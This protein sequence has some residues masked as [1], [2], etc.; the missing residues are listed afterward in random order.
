[1]TYGGHAERGF[2]MANLVAKITL[3]LIF[4]LPTLGLAA[5]LPRP[6]QAPVKD[7]PDALVL[8]R[9][10]DQARVYCPR[11]DL[12]WINLRSLVFHIE[13]CGDPIFKARTVSGAYVCK[14]E[15]EKWPG[16]SADSRYQKCN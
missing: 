10:E 8:F 7:D 4:T 12:A 16:A 5:D 15:A 9:T 6:D 1:L 11:D 14:S 3:A 2:V 13:K